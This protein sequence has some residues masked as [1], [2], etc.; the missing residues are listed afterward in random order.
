MIRVILVDDQI[1]VRHGLRMRLMLEPDMLVV[2]EAGDGQE[3]LHLALS[4]SPD[5]V[6]MDIEMPGMD[7]IAATEAMKAQAPQSAVVMLSIYADTLTRTRA[8]V[9][10]AVAFVEKQGTTG[11][12]LATIRQIVRSEQSASLEQDWSDEIGKV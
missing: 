9:A 1:T 6:L 10:G 8:Q 11:E 4:L 7:G 12:L 2:G 5:V 3:A